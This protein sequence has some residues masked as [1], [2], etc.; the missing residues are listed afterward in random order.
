MYPIPTHLKDILTLLGEENDEFQVYGSI[1]CECG[2]EAFHL[3]A[4][5]DPEDDDN[6]ISPLKAICKN[7][8]EEYLI[9]DET[10]HGWN[11]FVCHDGN[12]IP[13]ELLTEMHCPECDCDIHEIKVSI[14]S[15]GKQDFIDEAGIDSD[16][17]MSEDD[18][19][20]AFEWI[21]IGVKCLDCG[22]DNEEWLDLETM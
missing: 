14:S 13:D 12:E 2:C 9:F 19:V 17:D 1:K 6:Y 4:Y 5:A 7:C 16:S 11:G 15:Q 22:Y 21:S 20:N 18:W 3:L 8:G 10:K